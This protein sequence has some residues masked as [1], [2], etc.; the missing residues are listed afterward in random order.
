MIW[1]YN[2]P[3]FIGKAMLTWA[4]RNEIKLRLIESGKS[5]QN[6]Y[7]ESFNV[8]FRDEYL[9]DHC[10]TNLAIARSVVDYW[11]REY[12]VERPKKSPA[13]LTPAQ[14]AKT[15]TSTAIT[16]LEDARASRY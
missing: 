1:T 7:V 15:L 11:R 16:M 5:N 4:Q 8:R 3:N 2:D 10:F 12:N 14:C 9:D 6:S 13:G